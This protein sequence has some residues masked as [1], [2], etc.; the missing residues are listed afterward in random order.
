MAFQHTADK[1][2]SRTGWSRWLLSHQIPYKRNVLLRTTMYGFIVYWI[3]MGIHPKDWK[4]WAVENSLVVLSVIALVVM[5]RIY[6]YSNLSYILIAL[7]LVIHVFA[8]HYTYQD[9][10][11]DEWMKHTFHIKRGFYDRVVHFAYGLMIAFPLRET[12]LYFL[13]LQFVRNYIVT[14]M[15]MVAS[16]GIY[17]LLEAWSA[18]IFNSKLATQFVGL[19]GD[20]FDSQKDMTMAMVGVLLAIGIFWIMHARRRT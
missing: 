16:S 12:V 5:Y 18:L 8:A 9:T 6:P 10:P 14:F 3:C 19:Q 13:K 15:I 17:E 11:I 4:V 1:P 2:F 7:F 20:P